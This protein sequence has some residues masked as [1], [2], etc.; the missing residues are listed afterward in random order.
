MKWFKHD[1]DTL[2]DE[3]IHKLILRHGAI[4]YAVY[5]HCLELIAGSVDNSNFTFELKHDSELIADDLKISGNGTKSGQQIVEEIMY[6]IVDLN[7]FEESQGHIFCFK[8]LSRMDSS[9]SSNPQFRKLI[10]AA[11][12][13]NGMP[14]IENKTEEKKP[15]KKFE[16]PTVE[17]IADYCK[18]ENLNV[19][20]ENFFTYYES[21]GWKVGRNPM[22]NWKMAIKR[23]SM[24]NY[25]NKA[26]SKK[27][28]LVEKSGNDTVKLDGG[29]KF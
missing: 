2:M 18:Q 23:W 8:L 22:K 27:E 1:S 9:M 24:N 25:G 3:K 26:G 28:S 15:V 11:K 13:E 29:I 7:L 12:D 21:N 5:F 14:E 17:E 10:Q 19:N 20:P 16:K 4:G 6:T